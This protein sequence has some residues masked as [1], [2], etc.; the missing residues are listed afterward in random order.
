VVRLQNYDAEVIEAWKLICDVSRRG[1][2]AFMFEAGNFLSVC[3]GHLIYTEF[4]NIYRRLGV[5]VTERGE[6][7]Y[8]SMMLDVIHDLESK[9]KDDCSFNFMI[10]FIL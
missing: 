4:E 2:Y 7:F 3:Y 8:Q 5:R 1:E 10:S 6:S 9:G